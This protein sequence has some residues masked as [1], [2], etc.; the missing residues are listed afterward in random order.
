M[1]QKEAGISDVRL[2]LSAEEADAL[3]LFKT[4][5]VIG[6]ALLCRSEMTALGDAKGFLAECMRRQVLIASEIAPS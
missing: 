3:A 1:P 6:E 5:Q 2:F 4:R